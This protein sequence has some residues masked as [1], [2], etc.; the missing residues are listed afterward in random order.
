[1]KKL[2]PILLII[3][4]QGN[5]VSQEFPI[6]K[7]SYS[8]QEPIHIIEVFK[9]HQKT[10]YENKFKTISAYYFKNGKLKNGKE[11]IRDEYDSTG[12]IIKKTEK[13]NF[14]S[15]YQTETFYRYD[16]LGRI[17]KINE[18]NTLS[19]LRQY[20][21]LIY[22]DDLVVRAIVYPRALRGKYV[23]DTIHYEYNLNKSIKSKTLTTDAYYPIEK[24]FYHYNDLGEVFID[25]KERDTMVYYGPKDRCGRII[26]KP[27][28]SS[29]Y[30][31][32]KT[33][34]DENCNPID[35]KIYSLFND[36]WYLSNHW[37]YKY[38]KNLKIEEFGYGCGQSIG[39]CNGKIKLRHHTKY[40][41]LAN[42]F[43]SEKHSLNKRGKIKYIIKYEYEK[44]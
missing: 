19:N 27:V 30:E 40:I 39:N 6:A 13:Y 23:H 18:T 28:D 2:L 24:L 4:F 10:N 37:V 12:N 22:Q 38:E 9:T 5:V 16:S 7:W 29:D 36:K 21:E 31:Y 25:Q 33:E 34:Y 3:L 32:G 35:E 17:W 44:Y 11:I 26:S 43:L 41:Y 1:M 20:V 8:Y 15:K 14:K 42:G